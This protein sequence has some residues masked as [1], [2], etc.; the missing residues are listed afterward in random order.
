[1]TAL[2]PLEAGFATRF[3]TSVRKRACLFVG[4]H[5]EYDKIDL[6]KCGNI[7]PIGTEADYHWAIA[8]ITAVLRA[9]RSLA[10]PM[11]TASTFSQLL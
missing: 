6:E 5:K 2:K 11:V 3:L 1:M 10:L 9:S 7:R 8:E 4:T